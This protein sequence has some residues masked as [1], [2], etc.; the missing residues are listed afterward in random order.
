VPIVSSEPDDEYSP[1]VKTISPV[2]KT[3]SSVVKLVQRSYGCMEGDTRERR[4]VPLKKGRL[5]KWAKNI[6]ASCSP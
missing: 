1:V 5:K 3:M 2:V 6:N 4:G